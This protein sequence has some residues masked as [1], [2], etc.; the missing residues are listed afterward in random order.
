ML[1]RPTTH[2]TKQQA[3][4][5]LARGALLIVI[6]ALTLPATAGATI[7]VNRG[8]FGVNIG[9]TMTQVRVTLGA[10][11]ASLRDGGR[12][13]WRYPRRRLW[14]MFTGRRMLLHYLETTNPNQRTARG[15]GIGSREGDVERLVAGSQCGV[16]PGF[17]GI[18][19][20]VFTRQAGKTVGTDFAINTHGRVDDVSIDWLR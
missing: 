4:R 3:R 13:F 8:I 16:T 10:A 18:D 9:E 20:F 17:P 7:A 15:V 12:V 5:E 19:C 11:P 6:I 1:L 2:R 14:L